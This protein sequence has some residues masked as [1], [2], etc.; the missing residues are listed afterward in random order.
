MSKVM[1]RQP[2]GGKA[3]VANHFLAR[4]EGALETVRR[5][6]FELFEG[7]GGGPGKELDDWLQA[8]ADFFFL[9]QAE[10]DET[11][12]AFKLKISAPGYLADEIEVIALPWELFVEAKTAK[13]LEARSDCVQFGRLKSRFLCR[14]FDLTAPIATNQVTARIDEGQLTI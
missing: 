8:E 6:A 1:V 13:R 9:P 10:V 4:A 14:R 2:N 7:R 11:A 12:T 5:R 3:A